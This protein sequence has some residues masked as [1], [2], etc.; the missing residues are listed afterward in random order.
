MDI[1]TV[2]FFGHR[3]IEDFFNVEK[4]LENVIKELISSHEYVDFLVGRNGDFDRIVSSAVIRAKR[5]LF[6]ANSSHVCILPYKIS[7]IEYYTAYY[8]EVEICDPS[9]QAHPM[10]AINIRN[11]YIVDRSDLIVCYVS[12]CKG[13]AFQA[14]KYA[15]KQGKI[16]INL[17]RP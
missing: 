9:A 7:G 15:E 13:G 1:F 5:T 14:V 8:D 2:G 6:C 4:G 3:Y 10:A 17:Y 11:R 16:I 12:R